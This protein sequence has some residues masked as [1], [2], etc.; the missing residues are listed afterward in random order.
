MDLWALTPIW[1][2]LLTRL[3]GDHFAAFE[4]E[5]VVLLGVE[6][7]HGLDESRLRIR[8]RVHVRE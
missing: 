6:V 4:G 7:E 8:L 5:L 1:L 2:Q 3:T